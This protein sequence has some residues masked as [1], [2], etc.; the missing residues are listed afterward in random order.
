MSDIQTLRPGFVSPAATLAAT[1]TFNF[2]N[3]TEL[4][5][6]VAEIIFEG[7]ESVVKPI[8]KVLV[9]QN[10]IKIYQIPYALIDIVKNRHFMSEKTKGKRLDKG[11]EICNNV[12]SVT[13]TTG[14][15]V[16]ALETFKMITFPLAAFAKPFT[17]VVSVLSIAA[18]ITQ[19]RTCL[20]AWKFKR[21]LNKSKDF[22]EMTDLIKQHQAEDKKFISNTF[23]TTEEKLLD[24]LS[25]IQGKEDV[26]K[27]AKGLKN[28]VRSYFISS[29]IS[30]VASTI[31]LIGTVI[32][33]GVTSTVL[34]WILLG[35]GT[36]VEVEQFLFKKY[37]EYKFSKA[38][39]L[40]RTPWEWVTC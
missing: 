38:V 1:N 28:R 37:T 10:I 5:K 31:A 11:L 2:D 15:F 35:V 20:K 14:A 19:Y 6:K 30:L 33:L 26:E 21:L 9:V 4:I 13:E 16:V 25:N 17:A 34:G 40:E 12:R 22:K 7:Y 29:V 32:L 8:Q 39:H 24:S 23:N 27:A 3:L 36:A 18:N